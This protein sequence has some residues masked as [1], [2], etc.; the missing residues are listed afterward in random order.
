[1]FTLRKNSAG[2]VR[3]SLTWPPVKKSDEGSSEANPSV[4]SSDCLIFVVKMYCSNAV[5]VDLKVCM[6]SLVK[7]LAAPTNVHSCA[8]GPDSISE[9]HNNNNNNCDVIA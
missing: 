7:S 6:V 3:S 8:G 1:M 5:K 4:L 2:V 9:H